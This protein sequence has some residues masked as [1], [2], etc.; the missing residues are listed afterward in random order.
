MCADILL[1]RATQ[2]I[3]INTRALNF[4]NFIPRSDFFCSVARDSLCEIVSEMAY[5]AG[6]SYQQTSSQ[7]DENVRWFSMQISKKIFNADDRISLY[8]FR[9]HTLYL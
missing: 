8:I 2:H 6:G 7:V 1:H 9:M 3:S 5:A 4:H